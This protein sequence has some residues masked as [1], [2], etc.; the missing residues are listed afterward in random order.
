MP[1]KGGLCFSHVASA[2]PVVSHNFLKLK[3]LLK[4][5]KSVSGHNRRSSHLGFYIPP[6]P[7]CLFYQ[8]IR[9]GS[10]HGS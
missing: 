4:F 9:P 2:L 3:R 1:K 7:L 10:E 5:S 8:I 6:P